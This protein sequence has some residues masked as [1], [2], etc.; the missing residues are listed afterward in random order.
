MWV[1]PSPGEQTEL[2]E[3]REVAER[4]FLLWKA[5]LGKYSYETLLNFVG[6]FVMHSQNQHGN[7]EFPY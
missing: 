4:F 1:D 3:T 7:R 2:K 6:N 5:V